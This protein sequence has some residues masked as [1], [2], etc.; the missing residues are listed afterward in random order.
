MFVRVLAGA[1]TAE[2]ERACCARPSGRGVP[3]VAVQTGTE[4][5]DI[6]YVLAT[7]VVMCSPGSG[8]PVEEIA[9]RHRGP[10]RRVRHRARR[11]AAG[12]SASR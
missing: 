7:E 11:E 2:D 6:P 3:V 10:A 1:P 12:R 8:F 9:A 5:F 4:V